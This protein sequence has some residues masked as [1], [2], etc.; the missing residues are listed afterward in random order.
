MEKD[1][2]VVVLDYKFGKPDPAHHRQMNRYVA[3][4]KRMGYIQVEG[5]LLYFTP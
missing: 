4:L 1:G 2:R 3:A 5:R